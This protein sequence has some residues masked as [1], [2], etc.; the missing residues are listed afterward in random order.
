MQVFAFFVHKPCTTQI[1]IFVI[2]PLVLPLLAFEFVFI[3]RYLHLEW[4]L[5]FQFLICKLL[6]LFCCYNCFTEWIPHFYDDWILHSRSP[7]S[8]VPKATKRRYVD[9]TVTWHFL[10][11]PARFSRFHSSFSTSFTT[12]SSIAMVLN[13]LFT[14]TKLLPNLMV[15]Q[16]TWPAPSH[17][18]PLTVYFIPFLNAKPKHLEKYID[19]YANYYQTHP[20]PLHILLQSQFWSCAAGVS[21]SDLGL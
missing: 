4:R 15:M 14:T 12:P 6:I 21:A 13:G 5:Q 7:L 10:F 20:R 1:R 9:M 19:L 16:S 3:F 18:R 2:V 17:L 11:F 8:D